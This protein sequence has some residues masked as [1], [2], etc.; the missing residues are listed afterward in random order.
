MLKRKFYQTLMMWKNAKDGKCLLVKGARQVGK[1]TLIERFAKD[2]YEN[3]V[4]LDFRKDPSLTDLFSGD[5]DI[6]TM[7][8]RNVRTG[9]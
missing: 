6:D 5:S 3:F 7:T 4:E 2:N 1:T 8:G 9:F